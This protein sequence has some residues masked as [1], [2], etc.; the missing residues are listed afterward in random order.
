MVKKW[1][2]ILIEDEIQAREY[3]KLLLLTRYNDIDVV[4]EAASVQQALMLF[5]QLKTI[6][7][8]FI[9]INLEANGR[10]AGLDL[11]FNINQR[12][13]PPWL[14]FIT[15]Y[16]YAITAVNNVHPLAYLLKPLDTSKLDAALD[17]MRRVYAHKAPLVRLID[18][19]SCIEVRHT[20][21]TKLG[22][23]E[24]RLEFIKPATIL[25]VRKNS[26]VGSI[27][28]K[29]L[30][31]DVLDGVT[32]TLAEWQ[33]KLKYAYFV[34]IHKSY[35]VNLRQAQGIHSH[36]FQKGTYQLAFKCCNEYLTIG[37]VFYNH[38]V[39]KL[40]SGDYL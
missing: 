17:Y 26:G 7:G 37:E 23:R 36:P 4:A 10:Q 20:L 12:E 30:T 18:N 11:A 27:H 3:L 32:G 16:D 1:R 5:E 33:E 39:E 8:A 28:I 21:T 29:L 13:K 2:V 24:K 9:D 15:A 40:Q 22:D 38:L 31:G 6:E 25:Y 35:F 19:E 34:K 14:I